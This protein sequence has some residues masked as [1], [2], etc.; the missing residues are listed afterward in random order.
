MAKKKLVINEEDFPSNSGVDRTAPLR[1]ERKKESVS[2]YVEREVEEVTKRI[3]QGRAIRRKKTFVQSIAETLVGN[4]SENIGSYILY[5][6]LAPTLKTMIKEAITG[7]LDMAL[8]G[9]PRSS[10]RPERE[11]STIS[12][13]KFYSRRDEERRSLPS[14]GRDRFGL[15][16]IFF[17]DHNDA[18]EILERMSDRLE[19][20]ETVSVAQYLDMC[21]IDSDTPK[22]T[23]NKWG[24]TSLKRARLTHTRFGYA[25]L[26]PEPEELD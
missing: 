12:Y 13:G 24:W 11:K 15:E 17:K 25:I 8:G 22:W 7:A 21:N 2:E 3:P 20:Y 18:E 4:G 19:D 23:L 6:V 5:E 14:R 26:L 1:E 9:S 10:G 16:D